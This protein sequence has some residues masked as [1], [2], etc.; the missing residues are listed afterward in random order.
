MDD[1]ERE[2]RGP[3]VP[4]DPLAVAI[5][6]VTAVRDRVG[7]TPASRES[8]AEAL[9]YKTLNG[10]SRRKLASLNHFELLSRT[11]TKYRISELARQ[12]LIPK[13][14][15]EYQASVRS[16]ARRPLFFQRLIAQYAD[17]ALPVM[18][19]NILVREYG[20]L[21]QSSEEVARVFRESME[22]AGLLRNGILYDADQ[23]DEAAGAL[24]AT[25]SELAPITTE[26]AKSLGLTPAETQHRISGADSQRYSVP[27]GRDGTVA[28]LE[29]PLPIRDEYFTKL[30]LWAAF[31]SQSLAE[32]GEVAPDTNQ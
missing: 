19:P 9:G 12:I 3:N 17:Q 4:S 10:T 18:L 8:I 30:R 29:I 16:A 31:M 15:V 20:I 6:L 22:F 2:Q 13:D 28:I 26:S 11:G 27:L 21:P 5:Q 25:R 1:T 23:A 32:D 7:F 14:Q 24:T